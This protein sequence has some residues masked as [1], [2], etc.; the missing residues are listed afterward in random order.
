MFTPTIRLLREG[1]FTNLR[2]LAASNALKYKVDQKVPKRSVCN[3]ATKETVF[4][5]RETFSKRFFKKHF[6]DLK[7]IFYCQEN[8][9]MSK[10]LYRTI[11]PDKEPFE[12]HY[13]S[14]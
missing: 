7:N 6:Y 11:H 10:V 5:T 9:W 3:D 2:C 12:N 8:P 1:F 14:E 4:V 13:F